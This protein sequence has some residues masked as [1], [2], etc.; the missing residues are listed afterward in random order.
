MV[1]Q[2]LKGQSARFGPLLLGRKLLCCGPIS[3]LRLIEMQSLLPRIRKR[4]ISLNRRCSLAAL[5]CQ[6]IVRRRENVRI[7]HPVLT[8][9]VEH[10]DP[11]AVPEELEMVGLDRFAQTLGLENNDA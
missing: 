4:L 8:E 11:F 1:G 6:D 7:V 3:S 9:R 10:V 2:A 5:S